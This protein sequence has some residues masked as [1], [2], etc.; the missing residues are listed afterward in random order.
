VIRER[1]VINKIASGEELTNDYCLY[2]SAPGDVEALC[3]FGAANCRG[4]HVLEGRDWPP[5]KRLSK[6]PPKQ[7]SGGSYSYSVNFRVDCFPTPFEKCRH[8]VNSA[9]DRSLNGK[10]I[11]QQ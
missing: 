4:T 2:D 3:N 10:A 1:K 6:R 7:H 8:F 5:Q 11:F 9:L